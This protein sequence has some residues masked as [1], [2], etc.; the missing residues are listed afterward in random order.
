MT[1]RQ[2][3]RVCYKCVEKLKK[4]CPRDTGN[5]SIN[6][7]KFKFVNEKK[8]TIYVDEKVAPYM[9]Y[10]NE[11]WVSDYWKGKKNPNEGWW[12]SGVGVL[13]NLIRKELKGKVK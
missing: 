13:V 3:H 10:T 4:L 2:F 11:P 7:I 5:L 9:V 8:F 1:L 12:N 6:G